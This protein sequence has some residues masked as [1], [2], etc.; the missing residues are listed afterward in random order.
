M[1]LVGRLTQGRSEQGLVAHA[2]A[3]RAGA[4]PARRA[5]DAAR[6]R[7]RARPGRPGAGARRRAPRRRRWG[8]CGSR[9]CPAWCSSCSPRCRWRSSR[10]ASG[11]G[12]WTATSTWSPGSRC[13]SWRPRCSCRCARSGS[14]FHAAADGVAAAA[15]AF[16]V[17]ETPV[18][19]AGTR[20]APDLRTATLRLDG[21]GGPDRRPAARPHGLDLVAAARHGRRADRPERRRQDH[22][23]SRSL[24]G[25]LRP[26][27]GPRVG[28]RR[29][30]RRPRP[31]ASLWA[32]V[33]WLPQR[34]VLEPG[35]I[36]ELVGGD[37]RSRATAAAL[38]GLD[39]VARDPAGRLGHRRSAAAARV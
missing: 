25:L 6:A 11:C 39:A 35:T 31:R 32:Q 21:V 19:A 16:E 24:L 27:D 2:A 30:P 20:T 14:Q 28:R 9:S 37:D 4:R 3:R 1:V 23:A 8:R 7:P 10:S 29:R 17:L 13:S 5:A 36:A 12:W 22:G 15:Q 18:P 34:P 33:S 38:T 26:D